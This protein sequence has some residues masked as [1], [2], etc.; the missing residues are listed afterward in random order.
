MERSGEECL[1][2]VISARDRHCYRA[3]VVPARLRELRVIIARPQH[4]VRAWIGKTCR[5]RGW[6]RR[7]AD[8][9][10]SAHSLGDGCRLLR[11]EPEPAW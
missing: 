8:D 11:H 6:N 2:H 9:R 3:I 1:R 5:L 7:D 4:P 10:T